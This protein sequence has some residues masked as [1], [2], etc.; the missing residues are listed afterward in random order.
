M[1]RIGVIEDEARMREE[2]CRYVEKTA[3]DFAEIQC[4]AYE[5]AERFLEDLFLLNLQSFHLE[6]NS[7]YEILILDIRLP[8][9]NGIELGRILRERGKDTKLLY[10]T[11]YAEYAAESYLVE[12]SQYILKESMDRRLPDILQRMISEEIEQK[13][14]YR[15]VGIKQDQGAKAKPIDWYMMTKEPYLHIGQPLVA[16]NAYEYRTYYPM[17]YIVGEETSSLIGCV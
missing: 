4:R 17:R 7:E 16:Y 3:G 15:I 1:I 14:D 11:S 9:I 2:V 12:A 5:S 13:K 6:E 10:L 8:G